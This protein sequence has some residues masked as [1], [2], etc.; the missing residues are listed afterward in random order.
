MKHNGK[1]LTLQ[2]RAKTFYFASFFLPKKIKKDVEILYI[3]CRYIDDL[4]DDFK[5]SKKK[6][7]SKL[8]LIKKD[9]KKTSSKDLVISNFINLMKKYSIDSSIPIDLIKGI[10]YDLNNSVDIRDMNEL[11][12]YA[13]RVAGTVGLMFC[14]I[15]K[16]NDKDQN[17]RAIQLGIAM[18]FT[19]ISRDINEDLKMDRIY[20]PKSIRTYKKKKKQEILNSFKLKESFASDLLNL[21]KITDLIYINA[22]KGIS[23]LNKK[24]AIPIS[25]A[26]ELYQRIGSKIMK[27]S[28]KVWTQRMYIN[29]IEKI[30]FTLIALKKLLFAKNFPVL[31]KIDDE[32]IKIL[33]R[34]NVKL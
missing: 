12:E 6:V 22:W 21:L 7:K 23:K 28:N 20:L 26:A 8:K 27:D 15:I 24:Y 33:K 1:N 17:L 29:F 9:L 2:K 32:V 5:E 14:R 10:E 25:I 16:E 30:Y 31:E 34:L 18:Q 3:F 4:G 13:Y 19:N 11:I